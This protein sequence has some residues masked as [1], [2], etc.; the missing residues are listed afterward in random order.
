MEGDHIGHQ[1]VKSDV[2][3]QLTSC[4]AA[5]A[6]NAKKIQYTMTNNVKNNEQEKSKQKQMKI[7]RS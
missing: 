2:S 6:L 3:I 5:A 7:K 1:F 4:C